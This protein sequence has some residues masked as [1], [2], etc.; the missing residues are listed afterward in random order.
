MHSDLLHRNLGSVIS[1]SIFSINRVRHTTITR[2][3]ELGLNNPE[4]ARLTG[5][6][7]PAVKNYKDLTPQSRQMINDR[8]CKNNLLRKSFS[9]TLKDFN[10]HFNKIYTDELGRNLGGIKNDVGC[11]NC[12]KKLGAPLGCYACG[13]DL[14]IPF[15]ADSHDFDHRFSSA[16]IT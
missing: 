16:L 5:V 3:M 13:A 10:E 2:G 7:I 8:F 12:P 4:L 15:I 14:F 9:W 11:S 1:S 6:T